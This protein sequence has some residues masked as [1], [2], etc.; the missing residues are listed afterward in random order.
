MNGCSFRDFS[1]FSSLSS[2]SKQFCHTESY[3]SIILINSNQVLFILDFKF[4]TQ[5]NGSL[6]KK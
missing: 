5:P 6:C 1:L 2:D 4:K 3:Y